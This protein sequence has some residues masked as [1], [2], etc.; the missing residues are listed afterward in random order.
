VRRYEEYFEAYRSIY[1]ATKDTMRR[2]TELAAKT[3]D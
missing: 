2:L 3:D 1:L